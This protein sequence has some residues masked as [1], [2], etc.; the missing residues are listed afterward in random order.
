MQLL[1]I[2]LS[3]LQFFV[4]VLVRKVTGVL[5]S[6]VTLLKGGHHGLMGDHHWTVP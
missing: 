5:L 3:F 1:Q 2:V 6:P 4:L